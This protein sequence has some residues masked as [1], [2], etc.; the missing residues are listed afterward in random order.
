MPSEWFANQLKAYQDDPDYQLE[1]LL[2]DIN[3]QLVLWMNRRGL[4]RSYLAER[5]GVSKA[6]VSKLLNGNTN[7][8]CKTLVRVAN[9]AHLVLNVQLEP[10]YV[11]RLQAWQEQA[12]APR[13]KVGLL[14]SEDEGTDESATAA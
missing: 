11:R 2:L 3:E 10:R 12:M 6:F 4:K 14:R 7:L 5:L 13:R 9:A 1:L 8:T